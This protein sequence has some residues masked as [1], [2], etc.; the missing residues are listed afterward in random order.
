MLFPIAFLFVLFL[1]N[2]EF[3][4]LNAEGVFII[5][6]LL[7]TLLF[8]VFASNDIGVLLDSTN[9]ELRSKLKDL[10]K[11]QQEILQENEKL[12]YQLQTFNKRILPVF[13]FVLAVLEERNNVIKKINIAIYRNIIEKSCKELLIESALLRVENSNFLLQKILENYE[14]NLK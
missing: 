7:F 2:Y 11:L 6:F 5:S 10:T 8:Y 14:K 1:I 3:F 12:F 4:F 13:V 9:D